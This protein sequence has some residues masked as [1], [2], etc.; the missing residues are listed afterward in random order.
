MLFYLNLNYIYIFH[1]FRLRYYI[2]TKM[3]RPRISADA[4]SANILKFVDD[5]EDELGDYGDADFF[6]GV[7]DD[8]EEL[9]GDLGKY[10]QQKI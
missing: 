5:S 8:L 4:A 3:K 10:L 9:N 6:Q 1:I 2:I 7:P